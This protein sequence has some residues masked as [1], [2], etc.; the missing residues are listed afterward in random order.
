MQK[1]GEGS[2]ERTGLGL[3]S[4][5]WAAVQSMCLQLSHVLGRGGLGGGRSGDSATT[6]VSTRGRA[7]PRA[8]SASPFKGD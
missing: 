6:A 7:L 4:G 3:G 2:G 8:P 1:A 5:L